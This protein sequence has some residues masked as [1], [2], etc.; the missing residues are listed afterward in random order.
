M[1]DRTWLV[2][3]DG[4][5]YRGKGFGASAPLTEQLS[6]ED[7]IRFAGEAVFNTGMTGYHEIL[8][9]PSYTG[10]IVLMTYPHI[11]NYGDMDEWSERGP[12]KGRQERDIKCSGMIVR[13]LYTGPVP[14]GRMTLDA[15]MKKND[16]C[17]I[18]HVDTRAITLR[19]RDEGSCNAV[20]IQSKGHDLSDAERQ[21]IQTFFNDMPSMEGANL[22]QKVGSLEKYVS[23]EEGKYR[24]ALVDC[25]IKQNIINEME[26]LDCSVTLFPATVSSKELLDFRPDGVLISNGPGDPGVLEAQVELAKDIVGKVPVFGICLGHQLLS[27]ALGAE[28]FKMKF[29]HHGCNHPVR[30]EKTKKVFVTSQNHG[31]AVDKDSLPEGAFARFIN[32][33]DG[34]IEGVEV[35]QKK[36]L[37]VQFH[38]E[39][40]PGPVDSSWIFQAFLD[41]VKGE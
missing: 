2:L 30:D 34:S 5:E 40:A 1:Q 4:K 12:E 7:K 14:E 3:E 22:V 16:I 25:G 33:N 29:G 28:T 35:P 38:P 13:S 21:Q 11:G 10:Q 20:I 37:C 26:A 19:L 9:D 32:A 8:T 24:F 39:A 18:S 15:Y 41:V 27:Q 23:K 36:L 31:F 17:G 6:A